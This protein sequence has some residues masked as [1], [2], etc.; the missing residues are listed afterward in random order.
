M[1]GSFSRAEEMDIYKSQ[2]WEAKR[3]CILRR[4]EYKDQLLK[5]FGKLKQADRVHHIF[6]LGE[7]PEYAWDDWNLI[8][9][10]RST[11]NELHDRNTDEL[12]EKGAE[13]LRRT[14]R[15]QGIPIPEKYMHPI[16]RRPSHGRSV[17]YWTAQ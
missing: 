6:P 17:A 8:S 5:R 7:F 11:H 10:A 1:T 2:K 14:A 9:V 3:A 4:D 16:K 15:R 13:L 12:T